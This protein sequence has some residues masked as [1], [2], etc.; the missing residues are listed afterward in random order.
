MHR[1]ECDREAAG[2]DGGEAGAALNLDCA[3]RR[4][5]TTECLALM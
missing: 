4:R 3:D 2:R 5:I 1:R